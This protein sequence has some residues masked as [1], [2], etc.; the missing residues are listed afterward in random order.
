MITDL[1]VF[2]FFMEN[3]RIYEKYHEELNGPDIKFE[4][5]AIETLWPWLDFHMCR[6]KRMPEYDWL[7]YAIRTHGNISDRD[8]ESYTEAL[9]VIRQN[10]YEINYDQVYGY[11]WEID[12]YRAQTEL[13]QGSWQNYD[14]LLRTRKQR[15]EFLETL[16]S[17]DRMEDAVEEIIQV[18]TPETVERS[19]DSLMELQ[20]HSITTGI[21]AFDWMT[22][23]GYKPGTFNVCHAKSNGGKTLFLADQML[24]TLKHTDWVRSVF[25]ALDVNTREMLPR[26]MANVSKLPLGYE[27][28][29][30]RDIYRHRVSMGVDYDSWGDRCF[31]IRYP[32]GYKTAIQMRDAVRRIEDMCRAKD[33]ERGLCA[34]ENAG[35]VD[36]WLV[37]QLN[38]V[39]HSASEGKNTEMRHKYDH[40]C[41][42]FAGFS[43]A[44]GKVNL[45]GAQANR[46]GNF[47]DNLTDEHVGEHHGMKQHS[48]MFYNLA[49]NKADK[50]ANRL[51]IIVTKVKAAQ[52]DF[53]IPVKVNKRTMSV[54]FDEQVGV[55]YEDGTTHTE[56]A[57][58]H[59]EH[60][61]RVQGIPQSAEGEYTP[62]K[63]KQNKVGT[64]FAIQP[65]ASPFS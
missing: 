44:T 38:N 21:K 35:E 1:E 28:E 64:G 16:R 17:P 51:R 6:Y 19:W 41:L 47:V 49:Q 23:G 29:I 40:T 55:T 48:S 53:I 65:Q 2:R 12:S 57:R 20:G 7:Y 9:D 14:E 15:I 30:N 33:L 56:W 24:A 10:P 27:H 32:R 60:A 25:F 63:R 59:P 52:T 54:E 42:V 11:F 4:H 13:L 26:I 45:S 62:R 37:D 31:L 34:P 50:I 61:Q 36:F 8:K 5:P 22:G 3:P 43:E 39:K 18:F 46:A 58:A